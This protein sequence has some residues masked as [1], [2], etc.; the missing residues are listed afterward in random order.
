MF[1]KENYWQFYFSHWDDVE[2]ADV[3]ALN[4]WLITNGIAVKVQVETDPDGV[5][6]RFIPFDI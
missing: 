2:Q 5:T 3:E 6:F 1:S 4:E